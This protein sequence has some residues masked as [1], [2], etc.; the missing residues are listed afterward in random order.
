M[1]FPFFNGP[2]SGD[3]LIFGCLF[4]DVHP[5]L[6]GNDPIQFEYVLVEAETTNIYI[7]ICTKSY[8]IHSKQYT[9]LGTN[10]SLPKAHLKMIFLFPRWDS[11]M[12]HVLADVLLHTMEVT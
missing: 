3:M 8:Q 4:F 7:Y 9:L 1:K 12:V 5:W 2:I 10:M 6:F 11:Q